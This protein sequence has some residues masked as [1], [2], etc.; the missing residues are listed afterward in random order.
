MKN[1]SLIKRLAS[2]SL[3]STTFIFI[4]N[5]A[6]G[7]VIYTDLE[8]DIFLT[9][10]YDLY[11]FDI[12]NSGTN[13]LRFNNFSW[14][15]FSYTNFSYKTRQN[16]FFSVI[17]DGVS[18]AGLK[19]FTYYSGK[20]YYASALAS[21]QLINENNHWYN[22]TDGNSEFVMAARTY[23]NV[24]AGT[25]TLHCNN[26]FWYSESIPETINGYLAIK[27]NIAEEVHYGWI[28]CD[29]LDEG[30]T[31][32]IKDYAYESEPDNPIVAGDTVHYVGI[33]SIENT[34]EATVYSFGM[35][36]YILTETFKNTEVIICDLK[37]QEVVRKLLHSKNELINMGNNPAGM[38]L[39]TL[40]NE[41]K[42]YNKKVFIE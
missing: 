33:N 21:G 16:I 32:I 29:V 9:G 22:A 3:F 2:Y 23:I 15:Y 8:P 31:L 38:Y 13:E 10:P 18:I 7:E 12:D 11:L 27:F 6:V 36:I 14:T 30:R 17:E 40:L 26:C 25:G 5:C 34:I 39:V 37:G 35:D 41:G 4:H 24:G 20:N 28:R 19:D 42:R 1:T